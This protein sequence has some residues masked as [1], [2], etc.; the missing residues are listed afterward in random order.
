MFLV[1]Y[2]SSSHCKLNH[3]TG[4]LCPIG[5]S[6][7]VHPPFALST[8]CTL[9]L[10]LQCISQNKPTHGGTIVH[11]VVHLQFSRTE[12]SL[13]PTL[14]NIRLPYI[15]KHKHPGR[16]SHFIHTCITFHFPSTFPQHRSMEPA[17]RMAAGGAWDCLPKDIVSLIS[18]K[19]EETT[20]A[21]LEDLRSLRLCNRATKRA[22][23]SHAAANRFNLEHHYQSM[24]GGC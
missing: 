8:G 13:G 4:H 3:C 15:H 6:A 18:V 23:L 11:L 10:Y 20:E 1:D 17:K 24:V 12:A 19:V 22:S 21:L 2:P 14:L 16:R 7:A 9:C 5:S